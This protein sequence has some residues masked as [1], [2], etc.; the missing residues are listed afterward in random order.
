[1]MV[2][3][4]IS[5]TSLF[6]SIKSSLHRKTIQEYMYQTQHCNNNNIW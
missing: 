5:N 1:M 2:M 6:V 3:T 4:T